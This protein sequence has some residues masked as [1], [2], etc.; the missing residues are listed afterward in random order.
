M[1]TILVHSTPPSAQQLTCDGRAGLDCAF[2]LV[3]VDQLHDGRLDWRAISAV[4]RRRPTALREKSAA[5]RKAF[6]G[7]GHDGSALNVAL[8]SVLA[9]LRSV[10]A[11]L[12]SAPR[13]CSKC[14]R[15]NPPAFSIYSALGGLPQDPQCGGE[16]S[17][18]SQESCCRWVVKCGISV[19]P[20]GCA[21]RRTDQPHG[22]AGETGIAGEIRRSRP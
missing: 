9:P 21:L 20:T 6:I 14:C 17:L 1:T 15:R 4:A 11:A 16:S 12:W 10:L 3:S 19:D 22:T 13:A 8:R 7:A 18:G 2:E 5:G